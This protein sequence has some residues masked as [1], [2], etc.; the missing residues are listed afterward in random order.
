MDVFDKVIGQLPRY[1]VD[2]FKKIGQLPRYA[3]WIRLNSLVS[4]LDVFKIDGQPPRYE[5]WM[6]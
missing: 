1:R 3:D 6:C 5:Y 4:F 2:V